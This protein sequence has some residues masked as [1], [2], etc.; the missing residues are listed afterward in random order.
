M[1]NYY[2]IANHTR[3]ELVHYDDAVKHTHLNDEACKA[4]V[5]Y[6]RETSGDN[7]EFI[8]D[9]ASNYDSCEDEYKEIDLKKE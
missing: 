1:S 7:I 6:M 4:L 3:R 9:N 8:H 2:Y 5:L